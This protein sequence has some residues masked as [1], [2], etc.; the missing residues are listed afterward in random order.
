[1]PTDCEDTLLG[2]RY[3]RLWLTRHKHHGAPW[4]ISTLVEALETARS[5]KRGVVLPELPATM[6]ATMQI[7]S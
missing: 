6:P 2:D 1:M 3:I 5:H 7:A 4:L